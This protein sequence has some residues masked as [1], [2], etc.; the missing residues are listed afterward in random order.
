M[1]NP[2]YISLLPAGKPGG[3]QGTRITD[4]PRDGAMYQY[5]KAYNVYVESGIRHNQI[6]MKKYTNAGA[7][8]LLLDLKAGILQLAA[9]TK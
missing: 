9:D 1:S 7:A 6:G 2:V 3:L 8:N 5:F 4:E